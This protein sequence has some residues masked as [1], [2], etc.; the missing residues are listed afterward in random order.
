MKNKFLSGLLTI[1]LSFSLQLSVAQTAHTVAWDKTLGGSGEERLYSMQPTT[2]GGYI[3]GGYSNSGISGEKSE[4]SRGNYD[5]WVVK[6]DASG[7]RIWDKTYGGNFAD[8]LVSVIQTSDGGYI[9][10]GTSLSQISGDKTTARKGAED[11]WLVKLDAAG[12]KL[13]DKTIGSDGSDYLQALQQTADGGYILGGYSRSL[14]SADKSQDTKGEEDF[15]IVKLDGSGNKVWDKTIGGNFWDYFYTLDQTADGGYILGGN[16]YSTTS[17]DKSQGLIGAGDYWIVKLDAAGNKQWDKTIGGSNSESL[18]SVQQTADGGYILGGDSESNT[19]TFKSQNSKG[20]SDFWLVKLDQN[21]NKVWDK[22]IGGSGYETVYSNST[23]QTSDGGYL[24]G[25]H[26]NSPVSGD[27]TEASRGT[28]DYWIVK[29]DSLGNV[30]WDKTVG[31]T[32][33]DFLYGAHQ[34]SDGGFI[35]GGYCNA[36]IGGDKSQASRGNTDFWIAKITMNVLGIKESVSGLSFALSPNPNQGKFWLQINDLKSSK[37]EVTITD[38]LGRTIMYQELK[39]A[40][41][42]INQELSIPATKGM[43]LLQVKAGNQISTRKIVVE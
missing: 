19:G 23:R 13:W 26:T 24:V 4:G 36:G 7:N 30:K 16:S 22:T 9:L 29:L 1:G 10:G 20:G 32:A 27:K 3:L 14:S 18:Y 35:V 6:L 11:Y 40:S 17:G 41:N 31:S 37:A 5:Y 15:W 2:D 38:M 12:N 34:T 8:K 28:Y 21:G 39:A 42:Q 43:Y 33:S 25:G